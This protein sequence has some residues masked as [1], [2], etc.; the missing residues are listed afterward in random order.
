MGIFGWGK[1][2]DDSPTAQEKAL[3]EAVAT[4]ERSLTEEDLYM[5]KTIDR[6]SR[7]DIDVVERTAMARQLRDRYCAEAKERYEAEVKRL[8]SLP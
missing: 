2:P 7:E 6:V 5:A 4:L 1:K 8:N 3:A